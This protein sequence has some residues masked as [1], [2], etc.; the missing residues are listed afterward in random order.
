MRIDFGAVWAGF[1]IGTGVTWLFCVAAFM[2]PDFKSLDIANKRYCH[3]EM[4][5]LSTAD[6]L[7]LMDSDA[8]CRAVYFGRKDQ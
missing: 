8:V 5:H 4:K 2:I 6:S 7:V 1:I 3:A